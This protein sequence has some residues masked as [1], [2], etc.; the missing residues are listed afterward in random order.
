[1]RV[2]PCAQLKMTLLLAA[3]SVPL[4]TIF[5]T[6]AAINITRN[7]FPGKVREGQHGAVTQGPHT[8]TGSMAACAAVCHT[9][10]CA[11]PRAHLC[12]MQHPASPAFDCT[13]RADC[14]APAGMLVAIGP[15]LA[16]FCVHP[17]VPLERP[18]PRRASPP[19]TLPAG[20]NDCLTDCLTH[21]LAD[22][23]TG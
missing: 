13:S 4:N 16:H 23:L 15:R 22:W 10:H 11:A 1:M 14:D 19:L 18:P 5:G 21:S 9:C 17:C 7:D 8:I 6:V 2:Y 12:V 3:V 20:L